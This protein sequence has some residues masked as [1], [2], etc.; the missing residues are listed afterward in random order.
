LLSSTS[1]IF[2]IA[3]LS[4]GQPA[5]AIFGAGERTVLLV[6]GGVGANFSAREIQKGYDRR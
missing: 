5:C 1:R 3:Q 2:V 4:G 6:I